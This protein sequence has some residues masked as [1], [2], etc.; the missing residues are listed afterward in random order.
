[1]TL[2]WVI[3]AAMLGIAL[4]FVLPPLLQGAGKDTEDEDKKEANLDVYR[5]QRSELEA[6][7]RNGIISQ[8]QYNQDR[9]EIERRLLDDDRSLAKPPKL[10]QSKQAGGGRGPVY[11]IAFGIPVIAIALYL[12]VG[13]T[14][15]L[16][17][18]TT[19]PS[20]APF[21][22]GPKESGQMT[23][24]GIEANIAKLAKRLE[25]N[26]GDAEGWRM[27][28]RSYTSQEKFSEASKAY[29][30][31]SA[32]QPDDADLLADYAFTSAM[33]NGR[34][35][36]GRPF[37]LIKK[38]LQLD[39]QN[40]K[41]L[42]LAGSAEFQAKNYVQAIAYWQKV[43]AKTPADSELGRTLSERINDAK[44]LAAERR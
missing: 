22:A 13:N 20:Q 21:A 12:R 9:N 4:A 33:A 34:Q 25:Q 14:A 15:A 42:D 17:G 23:Q 35:L 18:I 1:M 44:S 43:L 30:N 39:P 2:F 6:D 41:A 40:A 10:K 37:E 16:T 24:Q 19:T 38:A 5:D 3:C 31:A 28:A 8:E 27:L 26:P 32:L 29:E 36:Q 7:L 11:A